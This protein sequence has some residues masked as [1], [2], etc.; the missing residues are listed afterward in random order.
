MRDGSTVPDKG[1]RVRVKLPL[2]VGGRAYRLNGKLG[3]VKRFFLAGVYTVGVHMDGEDGYRAFRP[4]E[5][6]VIG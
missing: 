1:A 5:L 6:E 4:E 2:S 3:T